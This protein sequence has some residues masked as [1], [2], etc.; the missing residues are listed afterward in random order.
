MSDPRYVVHIPA[1]QM[2]AYHSTPHTLVMRSMFTCLLHCMGYKQMRSYVI[3][4]LM[5]YVYLM[6]PHSLGTLNPLVIKIVTMHTAC[7][8]FPNHSARENIKNEKWKVKNEKWKNVKNEKW[9]MKNL[10]TITKHYNSQHLHVHFK[11]IPYNNKLCGNA[12][13][14]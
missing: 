1:S 3:G 8:L 2:T 12:T 13:F 6:R 4:P 5:G 7:I 9:N 14:Y 11:H 10:T